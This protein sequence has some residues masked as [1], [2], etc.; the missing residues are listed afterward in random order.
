[1]LGSTKEERKKGFEK[2][3]KDLKNQLGH[4]TPTRMATTKKEKKRKKKKYTSTKIL[5]R[6]WDHW[7]HRALLGW[8]CC[9]G[10]GRTQN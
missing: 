10:K 4:L 3:L 6:M 8:Y 9:C 7:N 5:T 2:S 1:M